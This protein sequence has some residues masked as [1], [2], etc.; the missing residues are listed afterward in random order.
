MRIAGFGT[1]KKE[2]ITQL[3]VDKLSTT[4]SDIIII[5]NY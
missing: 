1:L 3:D 2:L 4:L 5:A